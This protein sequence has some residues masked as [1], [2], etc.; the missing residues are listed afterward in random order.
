MKK[1]MLIGKIGS[2]KTTLIQAIKN[3][4]IE[5][6]KTQ[7]THYID[8]FIDMPGEYLENRTLYRAIII[9][10]VEADVICLIADATSSDNGFPEG[11]AS[12]FMK[13]TLG[14][15]TKSDKKDANIERAVGY[16]KLAG[17]K[18]VSITSAYYKQGIEEVMA[19]LEEA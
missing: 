5:Y 17:V 6:V 2:G 14:I 12:M 8:E 13:T 9:T 11:F 16:L 15:V 10:A 4:P 3:I 19:M 1:I 18:K 7:T